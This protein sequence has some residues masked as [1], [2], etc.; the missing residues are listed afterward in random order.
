MP[1]PYATP[2][3]VKN[4]LGITSSDH[5]A[6]LSR[7]CD[8]ANTEIEG[9]TH[10]AIGSSSVTSQ[11]IDGFGIHIQSGGYVIDYPPGIRSISTLE[12]RLTTGGSYSTIP[13]TDY[14]IRPEEPFRD[15]GWPGFYIHLT[16]LPSSGNE[17]PSING[18]FGAVRLTAA[19]GWAQMP[20]DLR[21]VAEVGVSRAWRAKEAGYQDDSGVDELGEITVSR[22]WSSR[23]WRII[24]RYAWKPVEVI[25]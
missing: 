12:L 25:D 16:D 6:V 18:A 5:D 21:G 23:D 1:L 20:S 13:S 17:V 7:M 15:P 3:N 8:E 11:L 4:R 2:A 10:R 24:R 9:N 14:F 22:F 19:I